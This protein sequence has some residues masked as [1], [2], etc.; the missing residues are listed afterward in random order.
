MTKSNKYLLGIFF[1][2]AITIFLVLSLL[3]FVPILSEYY[4]NILIFI[5]V[6]KWLI[7]A[8]LSINKDE[9]KKDKN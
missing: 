2:V 8:L 4:R 5:I 3:G 1:N 6:G 9:K 7:E